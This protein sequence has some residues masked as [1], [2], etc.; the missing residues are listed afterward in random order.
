M[1][2]RSV[3]TVDSLAWQ[4]QLAS[5]IR[6]PK[7]LLKL[8]ELDPSLL[9]GALKAHQDFPLRVPRPYL[10]RINKGDPTDPLLRQVLPLG[11]ELLAAPGYSEDPLDEQSANPI[12]LLLSPSLPLSRQQTRP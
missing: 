1:I 2:T 9:N 3:A 11:N 5:S 8:L 7:Q 6:N 4:E 10:Q 12:P